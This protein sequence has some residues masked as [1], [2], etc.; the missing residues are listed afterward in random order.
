MNPQFYL[1]TGV[2]AS[3]KSTVAECLAQELEPCAHV[4]G[5]AFRRMIA[6]GR[7][8]NRYTYPEALRQYA[9]RCDL[10]A[11]T[12]RTYFQ[13][14]FSVV[15]QD[16]YYGRALPDML[17]RLRGLPVR[18][19]RLCPRAGGRGAAGAGPRQDRL[20]TVF[21]ARAVRGLSAGNAGHRPCARQQCG[22][23]AADRCAH[24]R[25]PLGVKKSRPRI[26]PGAGKRG[27]AALRIR[28]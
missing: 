20:H 28:A 21:R 13:A 14:G 25:K 7:R 18:V 1:I 9:L 26:A 24:P 16:N 27:C 11:Q 8:E 12:A 19:V 15:L 4:R 6:S 17:E 3:G 23:A 10:A 5:D 22:D 2:M